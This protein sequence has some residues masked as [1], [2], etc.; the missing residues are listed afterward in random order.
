MSRANPAAATIRPE[1][2]RTGEIDSEI[3]N[4]VP[5][6]RRRSSR[7]ARSARPGDPGPDVEFLLA[8]RRV[9]RD[10]D[11][12]RL[13]DSLLGGVAVHLGRGVVPGQDPAVQVLGHDGVVGVLH[14]RGLVLGGFQHPALGDIPGEPAA[15]T[16]R[17][18][19]SRTGEIDSDTGNRVPSLWRRSVS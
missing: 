5:S 11:V 7:S 19:A 4:R 3:G 12:D 9:V 18:K 10:D 8:P 15:A 14:D 1:A 17:P 2:S 16:I 6:L 13:A